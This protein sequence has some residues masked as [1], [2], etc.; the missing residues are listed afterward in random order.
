MKRTKWKKRS[1]F[2]GKVGK[3]AKKHREEFRKSGA[4]LHNSVKFNSDVHLSRKYKRLADKLFDSLQLQGVYKVEEKKMDFETLLANLFQQ[5]RKPISIS[6][7]SNSW[8]DTIYNKTS[9]FIVALL[10]LLHNKKLLNMEKGFYIEHGSRMTRI[11]ATD[12]LLEVFPEYNVN[13]FYKPVQLVIKKDSKGKLLDYKDTAKTWRIRTILERVNNVNSKADIRYQQYKLNAYLRAIFIERFTWY[14]RLHTKGFMHYQGFWK[15]ER[16]EITINGDQIVELDY[17]GMHPHLL[18][19]AEGK[20]YSGDPYSVLDERMEVRPFLKE[21]LLC[22]L[23]AKDRTAAERAANYW[24]HK[25]PEE[26]EL[27]QFAGI[28]KARPLIDR[29]TEQHSKIAKYFCKGKATGMRIMNKDSK[30][31]LDVVNYFAKQDIPILAIHDSF[32]VQKQH[33]R[34]LYNTMKRVYKKHTGFDIKIK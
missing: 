6:L 21:I 18:Y 14:G 3:D 11:W 1:V 13:V 27:L 23:N 32:I 30:I 22:M 31:A 15:E 34:E 2:K 33:R 16:E 19:A 29:F 10:S 8:K 4:W 5:T 26:R 28:T 7:S 20:Q 17:S 25:N 24:L 9:Y 12:K